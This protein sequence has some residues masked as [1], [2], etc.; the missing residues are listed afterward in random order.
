MS[1]ALLERYQARVAAGEMEADPAQLAATERLAALAAALQRWR[2]SRGWS[3]TGLFGP[4]GEPPRGLYIH[5]KVGRGKT[6][7]MDLFFRSVAFEP[8]RRIHFHEFMAEVH[9]RI[10]EARKHIE[11]DPIPHVA[12][13]IAQ[14]CGLLCFDELHV[15]DIADAMILG[16]LFAGLFERKVVM[17][18]TSNAHPREL[19][20]NGLNRE[21][22]V[23]C[24]ELIERNM[25]VLELAAAKDFRLE[26]L[27]GQQLY[28][29]PVDETA[30]KALRAVFTRLTGVARGSPMDLDVKGRTLRVPEAARG[31]ARFTFS[32]L[33]EK[34]LGTLDYLHIAHAFHTVIIEG[35]PR[36]P[37]EKRNEA[38]RFINL[39]D[40]LYDARVG[41]IASAEA[42]PDQLYPSGDA[43][44]LFERTASRLIEMRSEAYLSGRMGRIKSAAVAT[45]AI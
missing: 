17:V 34:P 2:P 7:L 33:C 28:F 14:G 44:A 5:G 43:A 15:T 8:K 1:K 40:T 45:P 36:L 4:K 11:G 25:E 22:F 19:Y 10:G 12:S 23:P 21:L 27:A 39:I 35:I 24:I 29:T 38:R 42:E 30:R 3:L 18:A 41:L 9:D 31:V 32:D 37:P 26:K 20:L 13:Q 16:R 6:M